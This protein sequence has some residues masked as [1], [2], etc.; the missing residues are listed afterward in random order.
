MAYSNTA[1]GKLGDYANLRT[2]PAILSVAFIAASLY[3]FGGVS[4]I[5]LV[6]LGDYALTAEHSVW[7]SVGVFAIAF[8]SS[9]TRQFEAYE[10][11][12][13]V[14]I[15]AGPAVILGQQYV[16]QV[17]DLLLGFGDPLG[18]QIAFFIT[19]VSWGVAVQ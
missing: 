8:A 3:Q 16:P 17:N 18:H 6:W 9:E 19:I 7:T 4:N 12:E 14:A 13:K 11:W 5:T 2:L 10:D 1:R 15:G